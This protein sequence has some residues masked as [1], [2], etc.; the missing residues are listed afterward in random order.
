M[1]RTCIELTENRVAHSTHT[2]TIIVQ[3]AGNAC[4]ATEKVN[5]FDVKKRVKSERKK[6]K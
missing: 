2:Y 4:R 5:A 3:K 6:E 1:Q